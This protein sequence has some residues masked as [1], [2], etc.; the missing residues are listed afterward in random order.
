MDDAPAILTP[1]LAWLEPAQAAL[2]SEVASRC[3]L[4]LIAAGTPHIAG[5]SA[6][7]V[8]DNV[9]TFDDIRHAAATIDAKVVLLATGAPAEPSKDGRARAADTEFMRLC[10]ERGMAVIA[11]EPSPSS[12]AEYVQRSRNNPSEDADA[13]LFVPMLSASP[14]IAALREALANVGGIRTLSLASRCREGEGTLGARLYDTMHLV[15][16]LMGVP[17]SIDA[18][19]VTVTATPGVHPAPAETIGNLRGDLTANLR[20][21]SGRSATLSLSDRDGRWFRGGTILAD[22]ACVRFTEQGF[23]I[24]DHQGTLIDE[25][26]PK[27]KPGSRKKAPVLEDP[28]AVLAIS[29]QVSRLLDPRIPPPERF[30][31]AVVLAMCEAAILSARTGQGESP[32]TIL[33]MAGIV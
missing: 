3:G 18:A 12:A 23:E 9:V 2:V 10:R 27:P 33:R 21:A 20:F 16:E 19:V 1:T 24:T 15:H 4:E 5:R 29:Q 30:D 7:P 8:I 13:A 25:S 14:T 17:E 31:G 22:N 32:A 28:S 6:G 11:L 26:P